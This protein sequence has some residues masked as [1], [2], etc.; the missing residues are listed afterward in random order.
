M[1]DEKKIGVYICSGLEIGEAID[2]NALAEKVK[3]DSEVFLCKVNKD[4]CTKAGADE[5]RKDIETEELTGVVIAA[6]SARYHS[7]LFN[8]D[9]VLIE[10][11]NLREQV[12]WTHEHNDQHTFDLALDY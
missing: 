1:A 7:D 5:I 3:E 12:A 10:R 9:N 8:F 6:S 4:L 2:C 11:V